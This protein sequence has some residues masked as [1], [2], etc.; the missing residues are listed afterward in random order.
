METDLASLKRIQTFMLL[1]QRARKAGITPT[2]VS[3]PTEHG[4]NIN[5]VAMIDG[6]RDN[7]GLLFWDVTLLQDHG[8]VDRLDE[9]ELALGIN[10]TDGMVDDAEK[11][12]AF[13]EIELEKV[14]GR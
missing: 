3:T 12:L 10:L 4:D 5:A 7:A 9:E 1:I 13:V 2:F 14:S 8:L 6:K 11:I